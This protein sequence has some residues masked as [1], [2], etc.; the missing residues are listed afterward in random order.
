MKKTFITIFFVLLN[1]INAEQTM[2]P[3]VLAIIRQRE[4][5]IEKINKIYTSKLEEM[6]NK[7]T[8]QGDLEVAVSI[9]NLINST[10]KNQIS[11]KFIYLDNL[12]EENVRC[13]PYNKLGK[14]GC[15]IENKDPFTFDKKIP[16][17]SLFTHPQDG[18][19]SVDYKIPE[20]YSRFTG[21]VGL[22]DG[23][24]S[25]AAMIFRVLN[26]KIIL[27]ESQ[28]I[29][30]QNRSQKFDIN[31]KGRKQITLQVKSQGSDYA[32]H[33]VWLEPKLQ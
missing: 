5:A 26:G 4:S 7:Y 9:S 13:Y 30:N 19:A 3:D 25:R 20:E 10:E 6:K 32:A 11:T 1:N 2:P 33:A 28:P 29:T 16:E 14:L 21:T 24:I 8:K 27:W 22:S 17:H 31:I 15:G 12:L 18:I 23:A